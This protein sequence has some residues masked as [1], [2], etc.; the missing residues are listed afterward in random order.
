M[1]AKWLLVLWLGLIVVTCS[2]QSSKTSAQKANDEL[3]TRYNL[4]FVSERGKN[5]ASYANWTEWPGHDMLPYNSK[6][7]VRSSSRKITIVDLNT[8]RDITMEF[9]AKRMLMSAKEYVAMITSPTPVTYEGL[10]DVDLQGIQAGQAMTGMSKQGVMIAL[11]YPAKHRTPSTDENAWTYWKGRY[12]S[13]VVGFDNS[14]K[15]VSTG[16]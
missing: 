15:V 12:D 5:K 8:N 13:Y 10:S 14:G 3:Y 7:Q 16:R 6:V 4:H 11:G 9:S 2:C 1:K